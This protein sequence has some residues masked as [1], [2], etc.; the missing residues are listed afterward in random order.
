MC[1][2]LI[3]AKVEKSAR[4]CSGPQQLNN[5]VKGKKPVSRRASL[6]A[7]ERVYHTVLLFKSPTAAAQVCCAPVEGIAPAL[8]VPQGIHLEQLHSAFSRGEV[9]R[10]EWCWEKGSTLCMCRTTILPLTGPAGQVCEVMTITQDISRWG[11]E[12]TRMHKT[13]REAGAPKTFAQ[14][15]LAARENEKREIA[16][17]L[18][19]EIGTASVML[20]ALV[21]LAKQS[22]HQ[23][24]TQQ[25][26][27]DLDRLQQQT[28]QSM[29]RL[30]AIVVALRPPSLDTDGALRGSIEVLLD[31]VCHLGRLSYRFNC[32]ANMSEKGVADRVK[33]LLYRMVQEAI[34]NVIKH[35]QATQVEVSLKRTKGTLCLTIQDNGKGFIR[36]K[37]S[38]F[39]HVGLSAMEN[40][41]QLL[42]GQLK[43]SSKPGKGTLIQTVCP[44]M[45]YEEEDEN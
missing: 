19:D 14:I 39:H 35:A 3:S 27:A 36:K 18:H 21:S 7:P 10:Y 33:I 17:A 24:N 45:V 32:P 40:S 13:L 15:L 26:L 29:E 43:I 41:V 20:S 42:S 5:C 38:S 34:S 44:C 8:Q 11:E 28:Q 25:V 37:G 1:P 23:G 22:A 2:K 9:R 12:A 4:A 30:R 31:E 6:F 16:K